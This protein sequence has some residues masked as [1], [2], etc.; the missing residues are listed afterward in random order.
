V[1]DGDGPISALRL[2]VYASGALLGL[3]IW[4]GAGAIGIAMLLLGVLA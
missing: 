3:A 2:A 4:L 1:I